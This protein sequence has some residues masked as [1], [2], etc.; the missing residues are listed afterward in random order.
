VRTPLDTPLA[1]GVLRALEQAVDEPLVVLPSE[2][3]SV[4]VHLFGMPLLG[5]PTSNFDCNQHTADENLQLKFL[6]RGI[7]LFA[8]LFL[9]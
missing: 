8:A 1:V 5:L 7:N 6:F 2:G 9:G 3:G 4:P